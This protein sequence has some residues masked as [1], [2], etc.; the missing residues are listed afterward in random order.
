LHSKLLAHLAQHAH[1]HNPSHP[2]VALCDQAFPFGQ[3]LDR[4]PLAVAQAQ[5]LDTGQDNNVNCNGTASMVNTAPSFNA[6]AGDLAPT[7]QHLT[8]RGSVT[9]I[10][11]SD[12]NGPSVPFLRAASAT[13]GDRAHH[14]SQS[15]S[16]GTVG[17]PPAYPSSP[18]SSSASSSSSPS[19]S[20]S[21]SEGHLDVEQVRMGFLGVWTTL[22]K[23]YEK[24]CP[25]GEHRSPGVD[26]AMQRNQNRQHSSNSNNSSGGGG[27]ETPT[28]SSPTSARSLASSPTRAGS[29]TPGGGGGG[30]GGGGL[31]FNSNAMLSASPRDWRPFLSALL[32]TQ[33]FARFIDDR[34]VCRGDIEA[35]KEE[36]A[37]VAK[38]QQ[39][40]QQAASAA[41]AKHPAP[42]SSPPPGHTSL[43]SP[44]RAN[45]VVSQSTG[46]SRGS[47]LFS[48]PL[49]PAALSGGAHL[50]EDSGSDDDLSGETLDSVDAEAGLS[51]ST[52]MRGS[53][54]L[55]PPGRSS[56]TGH[57]RHGSFVVETSPTIVPAA[58]AAS[59]A[60]TSSSSSL[61]EVLPLCT[62]LPPPSLVSDSLDAHD[63]TAPPVLASILFFDE[64]VLASRNRK[65]AAA[66]RSRVGMGATTFPTPFLHDKSTAATRVV[67]APLPSTEGL[68]PNK[69]SGDGGT[70]T[71]GFS[72]P[73]VRSNAALDGRPA[74]VFPVFPLLDPSLYGT[75]RP[76]ATFALPTWSPPIHE[77]EVEVGAVDVP[78]YD[79][80]ESVVPSSP[81]S[82]VSAVDPASSS[83]SL[84]PAN[85]PRL[86]SHRPPP[87]PSTAT[88]P[89][90]SSSAGSRV[91]GADLDADAGGADHVSPSSP[92]S[93]SSS[94]G[95]IITNAVVHRGRESLRSA[96]VVQG[97]P[98]SSRIVA[99]QR[100]S[101]ADF[102]RNKGMG[103]NIT[104]LA[105][106]LSFESF[107]ERAA[108]AS[109]GGNGSSGGHRV[110]LAGKRASTATAPAALSSSSSAGAPAASSPIGNT[111]LHKWME[112]ERI[113]QEQLRAKEAAEERERERRRQQMQARAS[114]SSASSQPHPPPLPS[115]SSSVAASGV[116]SVA[117]TPG[118]SRRCSLAGGAF[119]FA[120][121]AAELASHPAL[122]GGAT[123]SGGGYSLT[124]KGM[125]SPSK[126][127][128]VGPRFS[129]MKRTSLTPVVGPPPVPISHSSANGMSMG[130]SGSA[131]S[132]AH[133]P[134]P[135][136]LSPSTNG[137]PGATRTPPPPARKPPPRPDAVP[138]MAATSPASSSSSNAT[139]QPTQPHPP[140]PFSGST[141]ATAPTMSGSFPAARIVKPP[142]S[143]SAVLDPQQQ[144]APQQ[145]Q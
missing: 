138:A 26:A 8:R 97:T 127:P 45:T 16:N 122:A 47:K 57:K 71:A 38:L 103:S 23:S 91:G 128:P 67:D 98:A 50:P 73:A 116:S 77:M 132:Q 107:Q 135:P 119:S 142:P 7:T 24:Y 56:V 21:S 54:P 1:I 42:T 134:Q 72:F 35:W 3:E 130:G 53:L 121:S 144:R 43:P 137:A 136:P 126:G 46:G 106:I 63:P 101:F 60:A 105:T 25:W 49:H 131:H 64:S 129:T 93:S 81:S 102:R 40:Q 41:T 6:G 75:P 139:L 36:Q 58:T 100:G 125:S 2:L 48:S 51:R 112:K 90:A 110:S 55:P 28:P 95:H 123:V 52:A 32:K 120:P 78:V 18:S 85:K 109:G 10:R 87:L 30:G 96:T 68:P 4:L 74:S 15:V 19:S 83:T 108:N 17:A 69:C 39:Q 76:V 33:M 79:E 89:T 145:Q 12:A 124:P 113:K 111:K 143:L 13:L 114:L 65:R 115:S 140:P 34:I 82:S 92:S 61:H 117:S 133:S 118:A 66:M 84:S 29:P 94:S 80:Q 99:G 20:L 22:L 11:T 31:W 104:A 59:S 62:T 37:K 44:S 86:P 27:S 141:S 5:A 70:Q 14:A 88:T 9:D